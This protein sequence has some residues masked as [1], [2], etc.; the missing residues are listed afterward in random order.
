MPIAS[1]RRAASSFPALSIP[2]P[3]SSF[4]GDRRHELQ[5]RLA[6]A[7]YAEIAAEGGGILSTV[8]ATR[9]AI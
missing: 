6:G 5:R 9:A 3:T 7:T 2:T 1:M 8:A 4:A